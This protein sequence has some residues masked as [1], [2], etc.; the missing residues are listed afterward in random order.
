MGLSSAGQDHRYAVRALSKS[1]SFAVVTVLSLGI[2]IGANTALFSLVDALLMRSLPVEAPDRLVNISRAS[3]TSKKIGLDAGTIDALNRLNTIFSGVTASSAM[4]TAG[5]R[6]RGPMPK[7][8]HGP[9]PKKS[10]MANGGSRS[11]PD[12]GGSRQY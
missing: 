7:A 6:A 2:G 9:R 5:R 12:R 4:P 11:Q 3:V 10:P 1:R 8:A